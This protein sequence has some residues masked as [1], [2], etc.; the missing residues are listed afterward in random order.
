MARKTKEERRIEAETEKAFKAHSSD[1]Q[2]DIFDLQKITD[3]GIK[4]GHEGKSIEEAVKAAIKQ[5]R[6]N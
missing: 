5:Y 2:F 4:A 1:V 3:A 6:Q